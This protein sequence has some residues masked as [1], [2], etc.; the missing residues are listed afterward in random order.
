MFPFQTSFNV[1]SPG[2]DADLGKLINPWT[3]RCVKRK[4]YNHLKI[5]YFTADGE[6]R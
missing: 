4:G 3:F 5:A 6:G 1:K 2:K